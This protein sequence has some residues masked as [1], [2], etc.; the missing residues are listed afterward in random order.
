[1]ILN[2]KI[3]DIVNLSEKALEILKEPDRI[4]QFKLRKHTPDD[5]PIDCFLVYHST[6]RGPPCKGGIRLSEDV[7]IEETAQLAEIMTYKNSLMGLPFG[8]GKSGIA[9]SRKLPPEA[10]SK[11]IS[12]FTHEIREEL[13]SGAYVPAPDIGTGPRE[14]AEIFDETHIQASVTGKPVGIGGLPG[15]EE[16]TGYGVVEAT[17]YAAENIID[18]SKSELTVAIQGFGNVGYWASKFLEESNLKVIAVSDSS[19]GVINQDGLDIDELEEY[20]QTEGSI[21]GYSNNKVSNQELLELDTDILIPAAIG[22]VITSEVADKIEAKIIVE[23]ANAPTTKEGEKILS[24]RNIPVIPDILANA[25][26]VIASYV[27]WRGGKSGSKTKR[28]E[29][30]Q[31]IKSSICEAFSETLKIYEEEDLT[32]REA[33][34]VVS[35]QRLRETMEGRGWV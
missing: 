27:E 19:G 3:T 12:G 16:A 4:I 23:G 22:G 30:Y 24:E 31:T 14:M 28:E 21:A 13:Y 5:K 8:G 26:G 9:A 20:K 29:T 6:A 2:K 15:R 10:K 35:A 17:L 18:K 32:Y 25:G 33:A 1:M 11:V 34:M 7:T